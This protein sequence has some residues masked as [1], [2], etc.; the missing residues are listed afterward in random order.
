VN[1][2]TIERY[3]QLLKLHVVPVLGAR[4]LQQ[5]K[6]TDID[7]LYATLRQRLSARTVHHVHTVLGSCFKTAVRK[8]E[9]RSNPVA[10]ADAP[11]AAASEA[12]SVL[13]QEQLG[14]L[15][16]GFRGS[17]L[18][19]LVMVAAFTGCRRGELLALRWSDFDPIA[20]TLRIERALDETKAHGLR[21]KGPKT[22]RG[23]RTI[24]LDDGLVELFKTERD[25]FLRAVAGVAS[26]APV[27]L[28][29][30]RLPAD[31]LMF[32]SPQDRSMPRDP[33]GLTKDFG[34]RA[35]K[36]G[37]PIRLHDLRGTHETLLL[38]AGVPV[39]T[40]AARGGHDP[41]VLLRHYAKRTKKADTSAAA[42]IGALSKAVLG[43]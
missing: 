2:R 4:S 43:G 18:Y 7:A 16:G 25:K 29:L 1:A 3:A 12:G 39:H 22:E 38:D 9:L 13:D 33:R 14:V 24:T 15:L 8:G 10:N 32:P 40:V 27:D 17:S 26:H 35:R 36:L 19:P 6:P 37:F 20:K 5:I 30:V 21:I 41:A 28:S 31:Q 42:V 34:R 11:R 23:K